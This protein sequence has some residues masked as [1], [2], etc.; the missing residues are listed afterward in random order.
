MKNVR[1]FLEW[2]FWDIVAAL[3]RRTMSV[4]TA[5]PFTGNESHPD[6]IALSSV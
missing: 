6:A 5:G 1:A 3:K 4:A 2:N